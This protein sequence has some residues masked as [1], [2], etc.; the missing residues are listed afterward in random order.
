MM[1]LMF[2]KIST[3]LEIAN[4]FCSALVV[5][6]TI[7]FPKLKFSI[8]LFLI[9]TILSLSRIGIQISF[10]EINSDFVFLGVQFILSS[11]I[12]YLVFLK[13]FQNIQRQILFIGAA[14]IWILIILGG[15]FNSSLKHT[16]L[17]NTVQMETLGFLGKEIL[18]THIVL[19]SLGGGFATL[20]LLSGLFYWKQLSNLKQKKFPKAIP[21]LNTLDNL[22]HWFNNLSLITISLSLASGF[23]LTQAGVNLSLVSPAKL[24]WAFGI[25]ASGILVLFFRL[26]FVKESKIKQKV[27]HLVEKINFFQ[28]PLWLFITL[29]SSALVILSLFGT[30]FKATGTQP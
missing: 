27:D 25:W 13:Q 18:F 17:H 4:A 2:E 3:N 20:N 8:G 23:L 11:I 29:F 30:V 9:G 19:A 14:S 26:S 6:L 22:C 21:S 7:F 5:L 1:P 10:S 12:L 28:F 16:D 15:F 24:I